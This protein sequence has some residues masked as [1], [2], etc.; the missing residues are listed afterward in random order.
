MK[1]PTTVITAEREMFDADWTNRLPATVTDAFT[2]SI[3]FSATLH[4]PG[5]ER[6]SITVT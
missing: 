3:S 1:S 4:E 5:M 2:C 6:A